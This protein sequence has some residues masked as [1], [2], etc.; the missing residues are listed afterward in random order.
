MKGIYSDWEMESGLDF[1]VV[2]FEY[3]KSTRMT[4]AHFHNYLE[5]THVRGGAI[6]YKFGDREVKAADGE[7]VLVNNIEPHAVF[8]TKERANLTV[9]GFRPEFVWKGSDDVDFRY[10]ENFFAG[11]ETFENL[12]RANVDYGR[13][14][15]A[16][17]E[18][19]FEEYK[20]RED[21]FKLMVKAKLLQLLTLLYRHQPRIAS[22]DRSRQFTKFKAVVDTM[23]ANVAAPL[24]LQACAR[25]TGYSPAYFS[26]SFHRIFGKRFCDY[27]T[28]IRVEKCCELLCR[29]DLPVQEIGAR[30]GMRNPANYIRLFR[31]EKGMT[32]LQYRKKYKKS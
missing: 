12:V 26:A 20:R 8:G 6:V 2:E 18:E 9:L 14:I 4:E 5:L 10:I 25:L 31:R 27:L 19:I 30:C 13:Q 15:G 1:F 21:G 23:H 3:T 29:T 11:E 22:E 32:P 28:R 16:L 17:L 7:V 24:S